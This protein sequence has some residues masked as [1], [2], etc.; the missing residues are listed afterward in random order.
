M[1]GYYRFP[2]LYNKQIIFVSEDDLWSVTLEDSRAI[3]LTSNI[4]Q[5]STPLLSPDGKWVAYV[6]REDGNTEVY[7]IPSQGGISQRL[8][9]DGF[10]ITKI[11]AWD[12]NKKIIYASDAKKPF[13]RIS[14]L[15]QISINGGKS[16]ALNYG[17]CSNI[18][19][20]KNNTVIG[21]NTQDPARWKR[22]KGGTAGELW[23]DKNNTFNFKK[24]ISINGNMACPMII[25]NKVYF[26]SDHNG[27]G[28]I[29]SC[30][31]NGK[32]LE[33]H[34][35]HKNYY[36]RNASTD[37]KSIVY[38]S[39]ADIYIYDVNKNESSK[40]N[41]EYN[42][43]FIKKVRKFDSAFNYLESIT[44]DSKGNVSNIITRG[45][46]FTMGNWDGPVIQHGV[47]QGVRYKH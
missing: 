2:T 47:N 6:G 8:T 41:I 35:F 27:I 45:K 10:F 15:R 37:K 46:N 21:R 43:G 4:S 42:S 12:G 22:Y 39:G 28:N 29:Y 33:Q 16:K 5:V 34:T 19:F 26:I 25:K 24:L 17:I 18:S 11:A 40:V 20:L 36:T 44:T 38:H 32:G 14:D 30:D 3:R 23:I 7:L 31:A 9:F 13:S 1:S